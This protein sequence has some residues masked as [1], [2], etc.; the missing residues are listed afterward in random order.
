M[1]SIQYTV[2]ASRED[3]HGII[4]LQKANLPVNITAKEK[5]EQGFVT[6]VH[7]LEDLEKLHNIEPHVL[8]MDNDRVIAYILAMTSASR[9]DIPILIPMFE[10]FDQVDYQRKTISSYQ[11]L[12]VGQVCVGKSYRG[13]GVLGR[14]YDEYRN[15][16]AKHYDF[17]ITEVDVTNIRSL[18]AHQRIGFKEV[19]RYRSS[20]GTDWSI[21]LWDW[22]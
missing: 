7:S 6:V 3:L 2:S 10:V 9:E 22:E 14:C 12:V 8:A 16:Y 11:Y 5:D 21:I 15:R 4:A 1:S 19:T 18:K 17:A 13:Q 20:D